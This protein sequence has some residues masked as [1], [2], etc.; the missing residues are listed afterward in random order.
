MEEFRG[1]GPVERGIGERGNGHGSRW[2]GPGEEGE[3][4]GRGERVEGEQGGGAWEK[5]MAGDYDHDEDNYGRD[6]DAD[7]A[8]QQTTLAHQRARSGAEGVAG[9]AGSHRVGWLCKVGSGGRWVGGWWMGRSVGGLAL[10]IGG[11][12]RLTIRCGSLRCELR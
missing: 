5:D 8:R 12:R 9:G 2:K 10:G 7:G 11:A 4:W 6:D 1:Y 3:D